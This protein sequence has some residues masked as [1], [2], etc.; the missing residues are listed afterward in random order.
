MKKISWAILVL[1]LG[2]SLFPQADNSCISLA[3]CH[4]LPV[5][6]TQQHCDENSLPLDLEL[7]ASPCSMEKEQVQDV[8]FSFPSPLMAG[9]LVSYNLFS[10]PRNLIYQT[11]HFKF[12]EYSLVKYLSQKTIQFLC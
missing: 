3:N 8:Q 12:Q 7:L 9:P 1:C 4:S 5:V 11:Y 2:F 10:Q 6:M